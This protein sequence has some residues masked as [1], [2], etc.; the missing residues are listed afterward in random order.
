MRR[1]GTTISLAACLV[2]L[3]GGT[4]MAANTVTIEQGVAV[5]IGATGVQVGVYLENDV[6]LSAAVLPL[7]IRAGTNGAYFTGTFS[8]DATG[9]V[10][11]SGL[12]DFATILYYNAPAAQTCSGPTSSTWSGG[13]GAPNADGSPDAYMFSGLVTISAY[14]P[15]GADAPGSPG[16][17]FNFDMGGQDGDFIIDTACMAPASHLMFVD[18]FVVPINP[19]FTAGT[20]TLLPNICPS[21]VTAVPDPVNAVVGAGAVCQISATDEDPI[22]YYM[23]AGPGAV[24]LTSGE[25]T[26]TP[27]CGDVPGFD[28]TIEATDKGEG[29]CVSTSLV[30]FHVNVAP[31]PL[32][33]GCGDVTVHWGDLA[34]QP[35]MVSG[36]CPPYMI[37]PSIGAMAGDWE[38][39]TAC[40]DLGT[41][42][43][44]I[45]VIDDVD[46]LEVCDFDLTV[47]NTLPVC[48]P[49]L[50]AILFP[51]NVNTSVVLDATDADGDGLIYTL[52]SGTGW[53]DEQIVGDTYSATRPSGD[54]A[55]YAV[56]YEVSDGCE[57]VTCTFDV[58]FENP[59]IG[60][61][62]L[63]TGEPY[64]EVLSGR[65]YTVGIKAAGGAIP[66]GEAG[67][68]DFLVCYD[69][70][71]LAFLEASM[72]GAPEGPGWEYFTY[73][74]GI[75]GGNCG[76]G[77]PDGYVR[78]IGIAD[79]NDG[80]PLDPANYN[81]DGDILAEL[82]FYVTADRNFI[83]TCL[84][85][86]FCSMDCGDN[87]VTD[88][89]G[90]IT[91]VPRDDGGVHWGPD[92]WTSCVDG[93]IDYVRE[94]SF[95]GGAICIIEPP[96]D[97]GDI[98]LNGIANEIGDAVLY[99]NYFIY[100]D[101]VW[102]PDALLREVQILATD[103]ND[104]GI[105]LTVA[106]LIYLTR[107]LTGD[108]NPYPAAPKLS[109]YANSV[110]VVTN[111]SD[112]AV[113][114]RTSSNS[115]L[116]GAA[117]VYR[118]SGVQVGTP[119]LVN[120]D[121]LRVRANAVGGELRVVVYPDYENGGSLPAGSH[122]LLRIPV[123]GEGSIELVE[124]Q[125][126]D[127]D[128]ALL[129]VNV[130]SARLPENYALL[131]NYPN[132]FNAGTVIPVNLKEATDWSL[133][134]YNVA[135]QV[136]KTFSGHDAGSINVAWDGRAD[137]GSSVASGMYF[138]RVAAGEFTATK[139]MVLLK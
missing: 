64:A 114:T 56:T 54:G 87:V 110:D 89:T 42:P 106:D 93:K 16:L 51:Q 92:Y 125:F 123:T 23:N 85:V 108:A 8:V 100:G 124:S 113:T 134:V 9:R 28:V 43:V 120:G 10:A 48:N 97:R 139:K 41:T 138:Y 90:Y 21:A 104:D 102:N 1:F 133:T 127:G 98:N 59:C 77:C 25:W 27:T 96:D 99:T 135:G 137:N 116:G 26:Y 68:F 11:G 24:G 55:A 94:I 111:V 58:I 107:I 12:L 17:T 22:E 5:G 129:T 115:D 31:T 112:G 34:T 20:I 136:V 30:T 86:D 61:V 46:Q 76:S 35:I 117:F 66:G 69:A 14:F 57:S 91:W 44:T 65:N 128:G 62:D 15:P 78:L 18:E 70:S 80:Y 71:G 121:N 67:G 82:T 72:P 122:D 118:Y 33:V 126:S 47:T 49:D 53:G 88:P 132:P 103:I 7:E 52:I 13:G 101:A 40:Q 38:Y 37:T 119:E 84:H 109:P 19:V 45:T 3:L 2:F 4:A 81:V 39:L 73:R 79:Q 6:D 32:V 130:A 63:D 60:V 74:T 75:L 83:N 131:Q 95:C 105:V 50:V 29:S 36:G